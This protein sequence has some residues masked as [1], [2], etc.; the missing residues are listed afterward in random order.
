MI[1]CYDYSSTQS[2]VFNNT[3]EAAKCLKITTRAI[4]RSIEH[5]WLVSNQFL[6]DD[7][8]ISQ[9]EI[10]HKKPLKYYIFDLIKSEIISFEKF[11]DLHNYMLLN[12]KLNVNQTTLCKAIERKT[13]CHKTFF[14]S[15]ENDFSFIE[16]HRNF[17]FISRKYSVIL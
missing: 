4:R 8:E 12:Y 16:K 7:E 9:L 14:C 3:S 2:Q 15:R 17:N 10:E 5:S 6:F 1:Y 11:S 13:F